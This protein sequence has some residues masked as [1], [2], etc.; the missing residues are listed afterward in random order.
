MRLR[1]GF[2]RLLRT[3]DDRGVVAVLDS[4]LW[5]RDYGRTLLADLPPCPTTDQR[6]DVARF[7]EMGPNGWGQ[8]VPK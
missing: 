8:R 2:G 3:N 4:R 1:Q 5:T 6:G 7:F